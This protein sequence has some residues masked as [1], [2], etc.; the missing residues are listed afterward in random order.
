MNGFYE[1]LKG[2]TDVP[3]AL[4]ALVLGILSKRNQ[5]KEWGDLFLL[6]FLTAI[7]G[8]AAHAFALSEALWRAIWVV[9]FAGMFEIDFMFTKLFSRY[10]NSSILFNE[11]RF[12]LMQIVFCLAA[13][14]A[15]AGFGHKEMLIYV[16]YSFCCLAFLA[17]CFIRTR[18]VPKKATFFVSLL[19]V[20]L[21]L[22]A[23]NAVIP[24]AVVIEHIVLTV[25][26]F[27]LYSISIDKQEG[28]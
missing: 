14:I 24:Y 16:V 26:L 25:I 21:L 18:N 15:V 10:V 12:R 1:A 3:I 2:F 20:L 11:K 8:T 27:V 5:R 13:V 19:P 22:Q 28:V 4:V 9:V 6:I 7:L 17:K 23:F